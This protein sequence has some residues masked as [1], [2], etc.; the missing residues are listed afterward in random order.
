MYLLLFSLMPKIAS[1]GGESTKGT[2]SSKGNKAAIPNMAVCWDAETLKRIAHPPTRA[3]IL[4]DSGYDIQVGAISMIRQE[5]G[6]D[7]AAQ[8]F[9]QGEICLLV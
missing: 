3:L 1:S 7:G 8:G 2:F 9:C 4:S 5:H 6:Y